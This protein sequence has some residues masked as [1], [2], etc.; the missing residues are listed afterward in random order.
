ML[1]QK[2]TF[3]RVNRFAAARIFV[4]FVVAVSMGA[5]ALIQ[6]QPPWR[7]AWFDTMQ[8]LFPRNTLEDSAGYP[9]RIIAIQE[10]AGGLRGQGT[11]PREQLAELVERVAEAGAVA[12]GLDLHLD[13]DGLY[14]RAAFQAG[15]AGREQQTRRLAG[16]IQNVPTVLTT[17]L[18]DEDGL[19]RFPS[20]RKRG[21]GINL[22]LSVDGRRVAVEQAVALFANALSMTESVE[23][24]PLLARSAAS[25]AIVH[26]DLV[27]PGVVRSLPA[28]RVL[29][30]NQQA[31]A[32]HDAMGLE[33]L[34]V[35][36]GWPAPVLEPGTLSTVRYRVSDTTVVP[37]DHRGQVAL[38]L[39]PRDE[40]IY[41]DASDVL[42]GKVDL[43][44]FRDR[45]V[46]ITGAYGDFVGT[47]ETP[48]FSLAPAAELTAQLIEQ[49]LTNAFLYRPDWMVWVET[50]F[51]LI[52]GLGIIAAA[53]SW[54]PQRTIRL[55]AGLTVLPLPLALVLFAFGGVLFDGL[56]MFVALSIV[57]IVAF[58]TALGERDRTYQ[59]TRVAL[60]EQRARQARISGE[61][62]FARRIQMGL[63]PPDRSEPVPG[64]EIACH[65]EP[66]REI[67]GDFYDHFVRPDGRV[68]FA[69]ADVSGK[70]VPASLFMTLSK[71]LW[72]SAALS[73]PSL[74]EIMYLAN[75]RI[76][77]DNKDQMFVT[78]IACLY[79]PATGV[80]AYCGAG[81]DMPLLMRP[82]QAPEAL[83][84]IS[85]PPMGLDPDTH[86]PAGEVVLQAGDMLCLFTDGLT[87]AE[88]PDH[89]L[90]GVDGLASMLDMV[91][92][93]PAGPDA[94][95]GALLASLRQATHGAPQTDDRT[96]VIIRAA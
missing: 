37:L 38:Y 34:R 4:L 67:G 78:G 93:P 30:R 32:R 48:L 91:C 21:V 11:W 83:P 14:E 52:A 55:T 40:R 13:R 57:G 31:T 75:R 29:T 72:K 68:Y 81:H 27:D 43:D 19:A 74:P 60:L 66:A 49:V 8:I 92:Q 86:Y 54:G 56:G 70:G 44:Q 64:I 39:R 59:E 1:E 25:I 45:F 23:P 69:I 63:L 26:N 85:G 36:L 94:A 3:Q 47:V 95:L 87:E 28:L 41:S 79:D 16:A 73:Q 82:G 15:S 18:L 42:A 46:I 80:L 61:L 62:D 35:G 9:V 89:G 76:A 84:E 65:I 10:R 77:R 88:I 17:V 58:A 96:V 22:G 20:L 71:G 2:L 12:V 51:V 53:R 50:A 24:N 5:A 7:A 6:W 33:M 90:M